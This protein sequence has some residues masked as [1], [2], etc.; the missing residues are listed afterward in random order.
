[1]GDFS[2]MGKNTMAGSTCKVT[3]SRQCAGMDGQVDQVEGRK[4]QD[5]VFLPALP[6]VRQAPLAEWK[7]Q[8]IP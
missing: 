3:I 1:M 4:R 8:R 5:P 2:P 6:G 7:Y